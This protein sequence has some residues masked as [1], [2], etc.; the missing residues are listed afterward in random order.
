MFHEY[1][2]EHL[3]DL[4]FVTSSKEGKLVDDF[5]ANEL[6]ACE[7]D[8]ELIKLQSWPIVM[9]DIDIL[10]NDDMWLN[11]N[12]LSMSSLSWPTSDYT[13]LQSSTMLLCIPIYYLHMLC[14]LRLPSVV[15]LLQSLKTQM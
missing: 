1:L 5:V 14:Y 2:I 8:S 9:D 15:S 4:A 11:D 3:K 7:V 6:W 13:K 12:I 10:L